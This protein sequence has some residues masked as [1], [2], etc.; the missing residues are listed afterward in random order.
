MTKKDAIK[1]DLF[2]IYEELYKTVGKNPSIFD[3]KFANR[4][5]YS[6]D[7]V[8]HVLDI[9]NENSVKEDSKK[10]TKKSPT[11]YIKNLD[12]LREY[13]YSTLVK[14]FDNTIATAEKNEILNNISISEFKRLS[15]IISTVPIGTK[16]TKRDLAEMIRY[17]F[18]DESRTSSLVR[19]LEF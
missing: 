19:G 14:I 8:A 12:D 2:L 15:S 17:Y 5:K 6:L 9:N 18:N 10:S 16:T 13:Y 1:K 7:E 3:K 11:E 4:F